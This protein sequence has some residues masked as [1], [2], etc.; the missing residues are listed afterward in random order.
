MA[1]K[2]PSSDLTYQEAWRENKSVETVWHTEGQ[3]F[4]CALAP[5]GG[6]IEACTDQIAV[7]LYKNMPSDAC[8]MW[9][10]HGFGDDA[11]NEYHVTSTKVTESRFPKLSRVSSVGF[12]WLSRF[13]YING[14]AT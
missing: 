12:D 6:D 10:F 4:L 1:E 9:A 5:H 14:G 2:I 13:E 11:F 3:D 7:E 8:S